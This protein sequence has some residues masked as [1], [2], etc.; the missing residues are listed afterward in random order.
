MSESGVVEAALAG[1]ART[2]PNTI[3]MR[4]RDRFDLALSISPVPAGRF[5]FTCS[6]AKE[7]TAFE[8]LFPFLSNTITQHPCQGSLFDRF[9]G[10]LLAGRV[11]LADC[12]SFWAAQAK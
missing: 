12:K 6:S 9:R 7:K 3:T 2:N 1:P 4:K 10:N 8:A 11:Q 5:L